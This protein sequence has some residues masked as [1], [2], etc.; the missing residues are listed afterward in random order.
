MLV[1]FKKVNAIYQ[2]HFKNSISNTGGNY[3]N[4]GIIGA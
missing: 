4:R 3:E 2:M 1:I